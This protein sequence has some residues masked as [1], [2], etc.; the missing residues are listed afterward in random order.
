MERVKI[1][2]DGSNFYHGLKTS[3]NNTKFDFKKFADLLCGSKK[4]LV[5]IHYYNT[6]VS[7][8]DHPEKY[9]SQQKFFSAIDHI[10][11]F[12][13]HYGRLVKRD[14]LATCPE[15][16]HEYTN[17]FRTEKGVDVSIATDMLVFAF[18]NQYDVDL[19][20]IIGP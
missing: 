14:E 9:K 12:T 17:Q 1:F 20:P 3:L 5:H 15:C 18:D 10:P 6:P 4:R 7:Q 11:H 19:P 8:Q 16:K 2:I 13:L